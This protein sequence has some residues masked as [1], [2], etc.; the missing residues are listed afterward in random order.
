MTGTGDAG[1][2][3][4]TIAGNALAHQPTGE[5]QN[6]EHKLKVLQIPIS[7]GVPLP[8]MDAEI[9]EAAAEV[10]PQEEGSI[11]QEDIEQRTDPLLMKALNATIIGFA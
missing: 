5:G 3:A 2:P 11:H 6:D 7:S 9:T 4:H 8:T 10:S 1:V